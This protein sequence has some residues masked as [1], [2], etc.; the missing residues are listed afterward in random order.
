MC[1]H[2]PSAVLTQFGPALLSPIGRVHGHEPDRADHVRE[3]R[4]GDPVGERAAREIL[5]A[6]SE[7]VAVSG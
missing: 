1:T 7:E 2:W 4:R 6:K 5:A 3:H